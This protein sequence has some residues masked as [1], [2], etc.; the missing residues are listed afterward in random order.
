M[1]VKA[2]VISLAKHISLEKTEFDLEDLIGGDSKTIEL[3]GQVTD[4]SKDH[5]FEFSI[6]ITVDEKVSVFKHIVK[7]VK[8]IKGEKS[9][10]SL[11]LEGGTF[12]EK[13]LQ[14]KGRYKFPVLKTATDPLFQSKNPVYYHG[15]KTKEG[16]E[17]TIFKNQ[18]GAFKAQ[19]AKPFIPKALN[20]LSFLMMDLNYDGKVDYYIRS[21]AKDDKGQYLLYSFF[22]ENGKPLFGENS[23]FRFEPTSVIL[24]LRKINFINFIPYQHE[25]L[26]KIAIPIFL[27]QG[28]IPDADQD[29]DPWTDKDT[30]KGFHFFYFE[31]VIEDGVASFKTRI[32]DNYK[33]L[34][35]IKKKLKLAWNDNVFLLELIPQSLEDHKKW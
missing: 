29:P 16:F 12:D 4:T 9:I 10:V 15:N 25:K 6:E 32:F 35:N 21:L 33:F 2:K 11:N 7:L 26:G 31:P 19:E 14:R 17:L 28:R 3:K 13:K 20:V 1:G 22:D 30:R 5:N 34:K 8:D 27:E 23:H 18:G 24:N